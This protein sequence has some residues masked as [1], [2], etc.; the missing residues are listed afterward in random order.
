MG[1]AL[2]AAAPAAA[3]ALALVQAGLDRAIH[4]A[5]CAVRQH[6]GSRTT[7]LSNPRCGSKKRLSRSPVERLE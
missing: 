4:P 5:R 2:K 3:L 1:R 7:K 6:K